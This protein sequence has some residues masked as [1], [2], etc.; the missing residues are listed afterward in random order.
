MIE[1]IFGILLITCGVCLINNEW[2]KLKI[3]WKSK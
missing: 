2:K 1:I 3:L